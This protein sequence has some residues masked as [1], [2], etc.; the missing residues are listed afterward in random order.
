VVGARSGSRPHYTTYGN[1]YGVRQRNGGS[2][3]RCLR[4]HR[5][6]IRA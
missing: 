2:A 6:V 1:S 3:Q 4:Q 5:C